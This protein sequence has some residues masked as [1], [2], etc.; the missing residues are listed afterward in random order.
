MK[1]EDIF[2][3]GRA[4]TPAQYDYLG[5]QPKGEVPKDFESGDKL[6][7][8]SGDLAYRAGTKEEYYI[9]LGTFVL[10]PSLTTFAKLVWLRD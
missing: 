7:F 9:D 8:N 1:L 5:Y 3:S 6:G 4:L 2:R 10:N